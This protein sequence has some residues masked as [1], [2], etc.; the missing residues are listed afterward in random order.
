MI[1]LAMLLSGVRIGMLR[2][3]AR[4]R[5]I[6]VVPLMARIVSFEV[7][8][9]LSVRRSF[10]VTGPAWRARVRHFHRRRPPVS[11]DSVSFVSR[12]PMA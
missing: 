11:S 12:G 8:I 1:C 7:T 5:L 10:G 4:T 9:A 6:R 2:Q 3:S